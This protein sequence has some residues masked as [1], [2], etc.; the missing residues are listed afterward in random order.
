MV[1]VDIT[2]VNDAPVVDN[3]GNTILATITEDDTGNA[4]QSVAAIIASAGG[5]RITDVDAGAIEGIAITGLSSGNGTWEYSVN[6]GSN[7]NSVGS[8][9]D[10]DGALAESD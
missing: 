5:D 3:S 10:S 6:G 7:W 1:N 4:G 9:S 2:A 8:V